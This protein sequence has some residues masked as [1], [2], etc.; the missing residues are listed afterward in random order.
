[1]TDDAQI[2]EV[3]RT[4]FRREG[5]TDVIAVRY[6]P[7]PGEGPGVSGD[8]LVNA[9]RALR[10]AAQRRC[11]PDYELLLYIAH[12]LL[13]LAGEE[14]RTPAQKRRMRRLEQTVLR[15]VSG[16]SRIVGWTPGVFRRP[17]RSRR[18]GTS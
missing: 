7:V 16:A 9:E 12:G 17:R 1:V 11:S 10:S 15:A 18:E 14:D 2:A 8:I 5:P 3:N 4:L 6:D 13:H